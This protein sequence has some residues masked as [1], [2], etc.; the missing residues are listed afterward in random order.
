MKPIVAG[1][2]DNHFSVG[3]DGLLL[4]SEVGENFY[5]MTMFNN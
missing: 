2:C 3:G 4:V 5:K 1:L